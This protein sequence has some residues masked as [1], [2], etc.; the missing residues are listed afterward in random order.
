MLF[1]RSGSR[2]LK[3]FAVLFRWRRLIE[4]FRVCW[5]LAKWNGETYFPPSA[6]SPRP[7][8]NSL[9]PSSP[10]LSG[11]GSIYGMRV[12]EEAKLVI[13]LSEFNNRQIWL[14][15]KFFPP[16]YNEKE[17]CLP[18]RKTGLERGEILARGKL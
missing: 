4:P 7:S 10:L 9:N 6:S 5:L 18:I 14:D 13:K 17:R 11:G 12:H 1:L 15:D 2:P 16:I 8:D 3:T